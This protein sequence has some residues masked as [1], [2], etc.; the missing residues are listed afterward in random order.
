MIN[1]NST[2]IAIIG[3]GY[4]GLPLAVEFGKIFETIGF[5]FNKSRIKELLAGNDSTFEVEYHN[6]QE[7]TKLSYTTNTKDI[8]RISL[9]IIMFGLSFWLFLWFTIF[10]K[11]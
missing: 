10:R 9:F 8:Q 6:F 5:D 11:T 4:V 2:R 1:E 3:M 7:A